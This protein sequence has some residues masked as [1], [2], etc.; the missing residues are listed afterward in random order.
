[1][2]RMNRL[3]FLTPLVI[4]CETIFLCGT[5]FLIPE[6][7]AQKR[8][9]LPQPQQ[10]DDVIRIKSE[11]VQ[12][13]VTV[14]DRQG[15][16]VEGLQPEQFELRVDGRVQPIAF[17]DQVIAGGP[18]EEKKLVAAQ[19]PNGNTP[20]KSDSS[21]AN[22]EALKDRGRVIFFF[23]D[24]V[25][26]GA[27][28]LG[29]TR[30][31]LLRFVEKKMT[32]ND[33]VAIISTS[34][35]IGFL[36]QL[37]NSKAVLREAIDR[38]H[39]K[40]NIDSTSAAMK[41][42]ISEVDA[43]LV[44][45]HRDVRLFQY[46]VEATMN[47]FQTDAWNAALIVKQRI[48]Q[49]NAQSRPTELYT[50]Y[51]LENLMRSSAPLAGRKLVFF[52]SDGFIVDMKKSEAPNVLRRVAN[53]A[54]RVGAVVYTMDSRA[55]FSDPAVD[56]SKNGYVDFSSRQGGRLLEESKMPQE[57]LET[58]A[59]ETGGRAFLNPNDF[60]GA[61]AQA[62]RETSD[63]YLLDWRPDSESQRSGRSRLE[64]IVKGR[65]ELRVRMRRHIFDFKSDETASSAA[66]K[67]TASSGKSPEDE[68][69]ATLGSL[70]PHRELPT[71][72]SAGYVRT[73]NNGMLLNVSIQLDGAA[74]NFEGSDGKNQSEIDV[75]GVALD[76]RGSFSS[77]KQKLAVHRQ[78]VFSRSEHAIQWN[79]SLP[80][81]PG[82]YQ[83]RVAIRESATGRTGSAM[84]WI[85]IP[86]I[87]PGSLAFSNIFIGER[88]DEGAGVS[89]RVAVNVNHSFA[90]HSWM[91]YQAYLYNLVRVGNASELAFEVNVLRGNRVVFIL[92]TA[93]LG[94]TSANDPTSFPLSGE[95]NLEPFPPGHYTLQI[96]ARDRTAKTS[97]SQQTQFTIE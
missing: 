85:E 30:A 66:T 1:M 7:H 39:F 68:L 88:K 41:V 8:V 27:E 33:H 45:N 48:R 5:T 81:P 40:R 3:L 2:R 22:S 42:P 73:P 46:L 15:R 31:S 16:F 47:E 52:V 78:A 96:S 84:Q 90:R 75:L 4:L 69:R 60:D 17:F 37:T 80:L 64:V 20:P 65:P 38:L 97:I 51:G 21:P 56:A 82:L 91:R 23:I 95:I 11:L 70:Y 67:K 79:Q 72:L 36:Q 6:T 10:S 18:D 62:I 58:L 12:T 71:S 57:A 89:Q 59:D 34:G 35:Q 63:Y 13:D 32:D 77:F 93:K 19:N 87:E 61:L 50:L 54:A 76:D 29:R 92:P 28:S 44:A 94:S 24:D 49:I 26:L 74:L 83:V 55:M 25:H 14:V 43:N 86:K 53:E 9:E